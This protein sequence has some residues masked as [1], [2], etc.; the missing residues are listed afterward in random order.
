[1]AKVLVLFSDPAGTPNLRLDV[2]DRALAQ[3]ERKFSPSVTITRLHASQIDDIHSVIS[4]ECFD[5]IQFSGHGSPDGIFL[6]KL[7][8]TD[9]GELVS[10]Q[11]L[12]SLLDIAERPPTLVLIL[13]CYSNNSLPILTGIAPFVITAFGSI[14]DTICSQFVRGFYD[15]YFA[16]YSLQKAFDDS[17]HLLASKTIPAE[18]FRLDRR[19]FIEKNNSRYVESTPTG[20]RNTILLNLDNVAAH[21]GIFGMPEEELC[22]LLSRKLTIHYWIF[23][24]PRERCIIPIGRF[25]FGEFSWTNAA[26]EVACDT[27]MKIRSDVPPEHWRVWSRVL[28]S[29]NDLASH[30]YRRLDNPADPAHRNTLRQAIR[31]FEHNVA[32]FLL[33][34]KP[35]IKALGFLEALGNIE[36]VITHCEVAADQFELERYPQVVQALEEALTNYH[37]IID[38]IHPPIENAA[39][40]RECM[41][42]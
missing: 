21:L 4:S 14:R 36:F 17:I 3:L 33:P 26:D 16:G 11:R 9:G 20:K 23:S 22:H 34:L 15:R 37:E 25:L 32:R 19:C 41:D 35:D 27:I 1:M 29:Y 42:G 6:D 12:K 5:V 18:Q 30:E 38:R 2:E 31:L 10:P 24:V 7:D 8:L 40:K 28:V 13:S 39:G